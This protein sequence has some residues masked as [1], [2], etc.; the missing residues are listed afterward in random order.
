MTTTAPA[1]SPTVAPPPSPAPASTP[2][3]QKAQR[4]R[5][6]I[7][8]AAIAGVAV[9]LLV[10]FGFLAHN[11]PALMVLFVLAMLAAEL[12][13]FIASIL[14]I[15]NATTTKRLW[16]S[17]MCLLLSVGPW[18]VFSAYGVAYGLVSWLFMPS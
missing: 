6:R 4:F 5:P 8:L 18:F 9:L 14:A 2:E 3:A 12:L 1:E 13:G 7:K 16:A 17:W 11:T 15:R 10:G